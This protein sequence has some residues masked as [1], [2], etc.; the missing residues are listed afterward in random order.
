MSMLEKSGSHLLSAASD[1]KELESDGDKLHKLALTIGQLTKKLGTDKHTKNRQS[2]LILINQLEKT[3]TTFLHD[4][5]LL[6]SSLM[7]PLVESKRIISL[8]TVEYHH[9]IYVYTY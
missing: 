2:H 8:S 7:K 4:L 6:K 3:C 1:E 5:S 9:N